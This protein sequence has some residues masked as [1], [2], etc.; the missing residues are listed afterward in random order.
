MNTKIQKKMW[1]VSAR[2]YFYLQFC[3]GT[4]QDHQKIIF[5]TPKVKKNK[6]TYGIY[7]TKFASSTQKH[8]RK[9]SYGGYR[10]LQAQPKILKKLPEYQI[11]QSGR[12]FKKKVC[13]VH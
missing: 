1:R 4:P 7:P 11:Y 5:Y 3:M 10:S 13:L 9:N 12:T 8:L 6:D 2:R